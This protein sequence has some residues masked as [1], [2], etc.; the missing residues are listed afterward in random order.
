MSD[1]L[2]RS[3]TH[4]VYH[5]RLEYD[6]NVEIKSVVSP[7]GSPNGIVSRPGA[8]AYECRG[9][10]M[11]MGGRMN[12]WDVKSRSSVPFRWA[13]NYPSFNQNVVINDLIEKSHQLKADVL[14]DLVEGSQIWPSIKGL[15]ECLPQMAYHWRDLRKVIKTA[16]SG[17]LAWKFGVKPLVSDIKALRQSVPQLV[18][19]VDSMLDRPATRFSKTIDGTA[20]FDS[21]P[22]VFATLAGVNIYE[23]EWQG[24]LGSSPQIRYVLVVKPK[25]KFETKAFKALDLALKRFGTSPASLAWERIPFSFVADWFI[26][27]RGA[28]RGI[29]DALGTSPY[30]LVSFTRSTAYHLQTQGFHVRRTPCTGSEIFRIASG[31]VG[32]KHYERVL[33]SPG[34]NAPTWKPRFGKN[35]AGI[36]AAL[37]GQQLFK[38]LS[39]RVP[40]NKA[41]ALVK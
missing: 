10:V 18:A 28:L 24:L 36:T 22:D 32:Y 5:R 12:T 7:N 29:D 27:T 40:V 17:Y 1:G 16:S 23:R 26:D 38:A 11:D 31:T 20:V 9:S 15:C 21:S 2:G 25:Q 19:Q 14:L 33:V 4:E 37:I 3:L 41:L 8:D 34:A 30:E 6:F 39:V 13:I 35:Q